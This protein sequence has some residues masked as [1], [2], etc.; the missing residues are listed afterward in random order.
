MEV[1]K[2]A[3]LQATDEDTRRSYL[4]TGKTSR[5]TYNRFHDLWDASG[6]EPL[7]FPL[8]NILASAMVEMFT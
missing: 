1:Q 6:L 8:Q 7:Q 3:I 4:Y 5:A 2:Q